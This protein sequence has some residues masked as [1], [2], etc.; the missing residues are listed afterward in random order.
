MEIEVRDQ[1]ITVR[2][3]FYDRVFLQAGNKA[4]HIILDKEQAVELA[5]GLLQAL[6]DDED[7]DESAEALT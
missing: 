5:I 7:T 3:S 4:P 6:K 2:H 1:V